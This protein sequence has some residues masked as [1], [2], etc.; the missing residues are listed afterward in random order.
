MSYIVIIGT[1]DVLINYIYGSII[2]YW[3]CDN[4]IVAL[5]FNSVRIFTTSFNQLMSALLN[6]KIDSRSR[7]LSLISYTEITGF[8]NCLTFV[9]R[10]AYFFDWKKSVV[11]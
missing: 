3:S 5:K 4:I 2:S 6:F 10:L 11:V 8:P 1:C 7:S 9:I